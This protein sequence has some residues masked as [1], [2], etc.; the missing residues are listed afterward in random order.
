MTTPLP[1][2]LAP[3]AAGLSALTPELATALGPLLRRLDALA[4]EREPATDDHGTPDGHGGLARSGRPDQLLPSEWLLADEY[5]DEFLRR[6]VDGELLHLAPEFRTPAGRGR[7]VVL[8]DTG[9]AQAG[10]GRL[11]QLAA[12]LV[13]HRRAAARGTE[14]LV[15]IL[16]DRPGHW[17]D[18]DLAELLPHWLDA[19]RRTDPTPEDV[20]RA[21]GTLDAAD[22]AWVL[23]SPR[24]ADRLPSRRRVLASEEARWTAAGAGSVTVR[25]GEARAELPL[26]A[27]DIAVRALR[28]AEFRRSAPT[29]AALPAGPTGGAHPV[30]TTAARTLLARGA[31]AATLLAVNLPSGAPE[32]VTPVRTRRHELNGPVVAAGRLGRR[33][34]AL[35]VQGD[36]LVPYISGRPLGEPGQ[37][38]A[39]RVALGLHQAL[40]D[41]LLTGPVLPLLRAGDG[42][43]L[44]LDGRWWRIAPDGSVH[45]DGPV[46]PSAVGARYH[47]SRDPRAFDHPLPP[48]AQDAPHLVHGGTAVAWSADGK[49]WEVRT[50]AGDRSLITFREDAEVIGLVRH[51]DG[52]P[53]LITCSRSARVVRSVRADAVRTFSRFSGGV[54]PATVHPGLSLIAA[55]PHP[56]RI[57]VGDA[58]SG[59]IH[60]LI[61]SEQ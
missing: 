19:R 22:Q 3:W 42:L 52:R 20:R 56:G 39:D 47:R 2:A 31:N 34:V 16:G 28:G 55:E 50:P 43:A 14:L 41:T 12:L 60:H 51:D 17:L 27:T 38:T 10:A 8:A 29:A 6:L 54:T 35:S 59:R 61:G 25:L 23:T 37:Y 24:L 30:F 32:R 33:L 49:A 4:G 7:I 13:L 45:D 46:A 48:G 11:V 9:P 58:G 36:R 18:G 26:P 44:P 21:C 57:V 1:A 15:G 53:A 5:P 40:L